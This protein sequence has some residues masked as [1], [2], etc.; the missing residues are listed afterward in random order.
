MYLSAHSTPDCSPD[1][2]YANKATKEALLLSATFDG[3]KDFQLLFFINSKVAKR[4]IFMVSKSDASSDHTAWNNYNE[5]TSSTGYCIPTS[6]AI[7]M[8]YDVEKSFQA[9]EFECYAVCDANIH[10][11]GFHWNIADGWCE[12]WKSSDGVRGQGSGA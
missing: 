3:S 11:Y 8:M 4:H 9:N 1:Y 6:R 10:C 7:N 2:S 5:Y 12:L